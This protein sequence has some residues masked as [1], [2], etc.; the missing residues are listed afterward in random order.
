MICHAVQHTQIRPAPSQSIV[1]NRRMRHAR[2]WAKMRVRHIL[3]IDQ[4]QH[5]PFDSTPGIRFQIALPYSTATFHNLKVCRNGFIILL[6]RYRMRIILSGIFH[7]LV[8]LPINF[9]TFVA[10]H[11]LTTRP[12]FPGAV[13]FATFNSYHKHLYPIHDCFF[14]NERCKKRARLITPKPRRITVSIEP[15]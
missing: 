9:L 6:N 10:T 11:A 7:C 15:I 8:S 3:R 12:S 5:L 4:L 2:R 13:A 1:T 14:V